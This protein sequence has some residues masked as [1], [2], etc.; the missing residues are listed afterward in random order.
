MSGNVPEWGICHGQPHANRNRLSAG[1][2]YDWGMVMATNDMEETVT[3]R[4]T[5][6]DESWSH[7]TQG[8]GRQT[9]SD[10]IRAGVDGIRESD[11]TR[12]RV[13]TRC[14]SLV[15]QANSTRRRDSQDTKRYEEEARLSAADWREACQLVGSPGNPVSPK[16]VLA[17]VILESESW[18]QSGHDESEFNA[19]FVEDLL[20]SAVASA[21]NL[22][23]TL[24]L[25]TQ[26]GMVA[27]AIAAGTLIGA[28][29]S[30]GMVLRTPCG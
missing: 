24:R 2:W 19:G 21:L 3:L 27:W 23:Q 4:W 14:A 13:K 1:C 17:A 18:Q 30:L 9:A 26:E 7:W 29:A 20:I 25:G 10:V 28:A 11:A 5:M 6:D 12:D 16:Y 15:N 8:R 22:T